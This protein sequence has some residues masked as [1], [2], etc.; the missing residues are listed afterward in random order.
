[1]ILI[2]NKVKIHK[3]YVEIN[4]LILNNV[5]I[6]IPRL[7][8][9]VNAVFLTQIFKAECKYSIFAFSRFICAQSKNNQ[10]HIMCII[11]IP[12]FQK[13]NLIFSTDSMDVLS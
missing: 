4:E 5:V 11:L 8:H 12:P 6:L 1:M 7:Q 13:S 2:D 10:V 9:T 3:I